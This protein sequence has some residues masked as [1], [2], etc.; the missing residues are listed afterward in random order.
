MTDRVQLPSMNA[1][2]GIP[3]PGWDSREG[4]EATIE[5]LGRLLAPLQMADRNG[6]MDMLSRVIETQVIPHLV[7]VHAANRLDD[8][9]PEVVELTRLVAGLDPDAGAAYVEAMLE[10]G[11]AVDVLYLDVLAPAARRLG[12]FW[13]QDV[14]D[15]AEVTIGLLRLQ[16]L[17]NDL[18]RGTSP[19][20]RRGAGGRHALLA[21]VPG[22]QH[23]FGIAMVAEFF[24]RNGW[25]VRS[26]PLASIA[27]L[28]L[29]VRNEWYAVAGLSAGTSAVV[30]NVTACVQTIRAAS[31]NPAIAILAGGPLF[32]AHP[33]LVSIVGADATAADARAAAQMADSLLADQVFRD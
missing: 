25:Q 16:R 12:V 32:T 28:A 17:L 31:C 7:T 27:E 1:S 10:R 15:F 5:R 20:L 9:T 3:M 24:R 26:A 19:R 6:H 22:E 14:M 11:I 23:T 21:S 4:A 33:E 13:E 18:S 8:D 29:M 2:E 30:A